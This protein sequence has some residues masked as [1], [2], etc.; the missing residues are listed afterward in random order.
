[1]THPQS[2]IFGPSLVSNHKL[3][4]QDGH[5]RNCNWRMVQEGI[6]N[7]VS[8]EAIGIVTSKQEPCPISLRTITWPL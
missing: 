2:G 1:M 6:S 4:T 5:L 7:T 3:L 8:F